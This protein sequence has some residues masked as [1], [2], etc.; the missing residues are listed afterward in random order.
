MGNLLDALAIAAAGASKGYQVSK[1]I[2]RQLAEA[3]ARALIE[4]RDAAVRERAQS[5]AEADAP[6]IRALRQAQT[7]TAGLEGD[8]AK[9]NLGEGERK[10]KLGQTPITSNGLF[11]M[12]LLNQDVNI[13]G[14]MESFGQNSDLIN[15][16]QEEQYMSGHPSFYQRFS[17]TP[18]G[19]QR[20]P[21]LQL[22][23]DLMGPLTQYE[24]FDP[25]TIKSGLGARLEF[26]KE[27]Y[28][29][30]KALFGNIST[31]S[32]T[33]SSDDSNLSEEEAYQQYLDMVKGK[34]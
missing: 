6:S 18:K 11:R 30:I 2:Q 8:L 16:L 7:T 14:T 12:H 25:E 10:S 29:K 34:K 15:R 5:L 28:P 31:P 33:T 13:P 20:D 32:D 24:T 3:R 17:N 9:F 22:V 4:S 26:L 1:D 21:A 27:S 19:S 23:L